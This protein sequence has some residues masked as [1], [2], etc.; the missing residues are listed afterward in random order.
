MNFCHKLG[1]GVGRIPAQEACS[2]SAEASNKSSIYIEQKPVW[3]TSMTLK[4]DKFCEVISIDGVL[5]CGPNCHQGHCSTPEHRSLQ[6]L[7][8]QGR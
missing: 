4:T 5:T 1:Q 8:G 2:I 6:G 7:G 3:K